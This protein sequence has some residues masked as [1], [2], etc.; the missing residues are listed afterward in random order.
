MNRFGQWP[1]RPLPGLG[2]L[3]GITL[4]VMAGAGS[5]PH[6]AGA[7]AG[8]AGPA[9]PARAVSND[10]DTLVATV[11][12]VDLRARSI[13]LITGVGLAL[14]IRHARLPAPLTIKGIAPESLA[15]MLTPGC[16]VRVVLRATPAGPAASQVELLRA[17]PPR[18]KP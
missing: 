14:R 8:A 9:P 11:N 2:L 17:A 15:V 1:E 6:G 13:D 16:I 5:T 18:R 4:L 7:A 12:A 10:G 3:A